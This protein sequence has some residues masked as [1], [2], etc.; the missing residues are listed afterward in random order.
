MS[1][2]KRLKMSRAPRGVAA[3]PGIPHLHVHVHGVGRRHEPRGAARQAPRAS[4]GRR[5]RRTRPPILRRERSQ[6]AADVVRARVHFLFDVV[7]GLDVA[8]QVRDKRGVHA[9]LGVL[10]EQGQPG[11]LGDARVVRPQLVGTP[12]RN[13]R[14]Q[15]HDGGCAGARRVPGVHDCLR[16]GGSGDAGNNRN[17]ARGRADHRFDPG[18]ALVVRQVLEFASNGGIHDAVDTRPPQNS[19][20]AASASRSRRS[21]SSKGDCKTGKLPANATRR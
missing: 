4:S 6:H 19:T 12:R 8:H 2:N 10:H 16:A 11:G 5:S 21:A 17:G 15:R 18:A 9:R 3:L 13:D 1:G 7:H 14:R 20:S